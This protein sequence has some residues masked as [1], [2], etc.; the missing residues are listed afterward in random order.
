MDTSNTVIE[1]PSACQ[2]CGNTFP[3]NRR[4]VKDSSKNQYCTKTCM[5]VAQTKRA[6]ITLNC[7]YCTKDYETLKGRNNKRHQFCSQKCSLNV[8]MDRYFWSICNVLSQNTGWLSADMIRMKLREHKVDLTSMRIATRIA[9]NKLIEVQE[10]SEPYMYRLVK[11][12][13]NKPWCWHTSKFF[14]KLSVERHDYVLMFEGDVVRGQ[15]ASNSDK[16]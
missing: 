2:N 14:R 13:E 8:R 6:T 12:C 16:R 4:I 11:Q 7:S 10:E 15:D 9:H 5:G 1:P 3:P